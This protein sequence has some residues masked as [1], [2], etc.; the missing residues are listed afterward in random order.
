MD[1]PLVLDPCEW[2]GEPC[3]LAS[4]PRCADCAGQKPGELIRAAME[5]ML[6]RLARRAPSSPT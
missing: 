6:A 1:G 4:Y 3:E 5:R 2:C